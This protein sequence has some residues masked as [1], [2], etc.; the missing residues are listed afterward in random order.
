MSIIS[1]VEELEALYGLPGET[2]LVK[3]LDRIIPEYADFI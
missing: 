2:S 3:E 1:S